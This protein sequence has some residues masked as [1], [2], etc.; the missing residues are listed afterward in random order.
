MIVMMDIMIYLFVNIIQT[1]DI[2]LNTII[3]KIE[4]ALSSLSVGLNRIL[5]V[6]NVCI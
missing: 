6:G 5:S 1:R 2:S 4:N 3:E